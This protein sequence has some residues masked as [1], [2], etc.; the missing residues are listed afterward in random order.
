MCILSGPP[1]LLSRQ[2][3]AFLNPGGAN[4]VNLVRNLIRCSA[5]SLEDYS[6]CQFVGKG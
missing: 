6:T 3:V 4:T 1:S 2:A 5:L